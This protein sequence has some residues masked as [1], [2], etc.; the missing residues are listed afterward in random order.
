MAT[1]YKFVSSARSSVD[2]TMYELAD[3]QMERVLSG[4]AARGVDVRVLLDRAYHGSEINQP[5]AIALRAAGV[6]V[7][8]A[9]SRTIVHQKTITVDDA[10]SCIMT[11]NLTARYYS[12]D[13]DLA[14]FDTNPVDVAAI[15]SA[16]DRDDT[17]VPP[18]P[19][20]TGSGDLVW[21]PGSTAALVSLIASATTSID[22]ES[23][24][25]DDP[26]ITSA[27]TAAAHRGVDVRIV[28]EANS[29]WD[30]AFDQITAAGGHVFIYDSSGGLY[31][32]AKFVDVDDTTV[33]I[34]SENFTVASL[35][36]NR[37]LGIVLRDP[38]IARRVAHLFARDA[39]DASSYRGR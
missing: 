32:H 10:E 22:I 23:E 5:A 25:L 13:R 27:L 15:V 17:G 4:D 1:I 3:P 31:I 19:A 37:E 35:A 2:I 11:L 12:S 36:Y 20:S 28:M 7:G 34:G 18:D 24:E 16:F 33:W 8:W 29:R 39:A 38:A 14:V 9:N 30:P 21:S 6:H 26:A